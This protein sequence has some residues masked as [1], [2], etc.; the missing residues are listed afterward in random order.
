MSTKREPVTEDRLGNFKYFAKILPLLDRL[1]EAG[2]A[3]DKAGNRL[4]HFDQY[5]AL[6]LLFFFNPIVTSLRGLVQASHLR[7]VQQELGVSPTS[8]GSLS[9]AGNVFDAD[10]LK[11]IIAE[12]GLQ[13][14]P[15]THDAR[16]DDLPGVLTAVDGTELTAL[17]ELVEAG[18][19]GRGIKLHTHF[20]LLKG[21]PADMDLTL[22]NASEVNHLLAHLQPGR[23]YVKDR[24]YCCFRLFQ[25]IVDIGSHFVCRAR[26]NS[27][28]QII[29][30]RPLSAQAQAAGIVSDQVI[31]LGGVDSREQ[32][33]QPLRLIRIACRPHRKRHSGRGGP[34]Q[35][36]V[37]LIATDLLDVPAEV[38][39]LIYR[40]R[41]TVELFFRFFKQV[42]G[43]RH[44]LS[45]GANGIE[46][47]V[48]L[49]I[50]VCL[51]IALWTGRKPTLRTIEMIR[52]YFIGW[53]ELDELEAHIAKLPDLPA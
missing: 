2:C 8:L 4:L 41:W 43:C 25:A 5:I 44:L 17:A 47:Q 20:E 19:Q 21:V 13:L 26:D 46:I 16:L 32:L 36:E 27:V 18:W 24:G 10:L 40:K 52:F 3:R 31:W 1:H 53:A 50:I 6:Q 28:Y 39:A 29:Q 7:K 42:L 37:L 23:V 35:G 22:A 15:L 11:P 34:E 33:R 30:D 45:H 38:L 51:L 12:L 49:A 9:E 14:R 48:Y